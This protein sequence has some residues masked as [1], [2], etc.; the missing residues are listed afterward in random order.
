MIDRAVLNIVSLVLSGVGLFVVL[1]KFNVPELRTT[2]FDANPYA[3]KAE[4]I[5]KVMTVIFT[6]LTLIGIILQ[7][8][9]EIWSQSI[10]SERYPSLFYLLIF[11]FVL[12]ATIVLSI[13]LTYV[14]KRVARSVWFPRAIQQVT[15]QYVSARFIVEHDGWRE[16]QLAIKDNA[17]I[18]NRL[19]CRETNFKT[20]Q[21]RIVNIETLL[22]LPHYDGDLIARLDRLQPYF[23][24]KPSVDS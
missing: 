6:T 8:A 9:C 2:Y 4:T 19:Q 17:T 12:C 22:D 1:T 3:E 14:G 18:N 10:P 5:D 23:E 16:D 13:I 15:E 11:V 21:E 7:L 20:A 24:P